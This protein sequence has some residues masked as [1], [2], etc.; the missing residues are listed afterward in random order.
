MGNRPYK[1]TFEIHIEQGPILE[2]EEFSVG[3][4]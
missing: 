3:I 4:S 1:A 2:A